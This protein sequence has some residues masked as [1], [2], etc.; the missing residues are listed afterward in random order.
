MEI[1]GYIATIV[2]TAAGLIGLFLT[3]FGWKRRIVAAVSVCLVAATAY[4]TSEIVSK[5]G[6]VESTYRQASDLVESRRMRHTD[7]GFMLAALAFLEAKKN[8]LPD[9]Y[10]R[11]LQICERYGCVSPDRELSDKFVSIEGAS[12]LESILEGIAVMSEPQTA[13]KLTRP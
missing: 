13:P 8:Q 12:I 2:G 3:V 6:E 1:S 5:L 4:Y 10:E 11:A 9:T 7:Q